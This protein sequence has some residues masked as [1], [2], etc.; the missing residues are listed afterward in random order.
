[1]QGIF[2][3]DAAGIVKASVGFERLRGDAALFGGFLSAIQM[4]VRQMAGDEVRELKFGDLQLLITRLHED[5][6]V[7]L[8]NV[9]EETAHNTHKAVVKLVETRSGVVDSGFL[10]LIAD[11]TAIGEEVSEHTKTEMKSWIQR[12]LDEIRDR[13]KE[14]GKK[15]F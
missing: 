3:I 14:W 5:Y 7:T 12:E 9:S 4:F 15:V 2:I 10:E 6:I 1:M 11:L 8:H 13:S